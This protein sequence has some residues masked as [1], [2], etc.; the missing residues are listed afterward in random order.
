MQSTNAN[1]GS[2]TLTVDFDVATDPNIDQVL[3][4]EPRTRRR[5]RTCPQDVQATSASPS[6]S[7]P[8]SPADARS[9]STRPKGTYDALFLAN[10]A[11][12]QHQRPAVARARRRP[13]DRSSAPATTRCASGSSPTAARKLG[14]TVT[15]VLDALQQAEHREPGRPDRRRARA[16]RASSSP[17]RCARRDA[18]I[19]AGGVRRHRRA[20][21]PRRLR[22]CA[23]ATSARI[24]LGAQNYSMIG[25]LQRQAGGRSSPSSRCPGSNALDTVEPAPRR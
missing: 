24:E 16:R 13:R 4:A 14:L 10:Y 2:M 7:R 11:L 15:D 9:R 1:D 19:D 8:R 22:S 20:R 12:H 18:S 5:S 17:T 6:R 23:C 3:V 21:Q 25:T